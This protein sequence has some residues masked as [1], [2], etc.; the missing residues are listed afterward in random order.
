[1]I[2]EYE[3]RSTLGRFIMHI[4]NEALRGVGICS[5]S[6]V[7][8]NTFVYNKGEAQRVTIDEITYAMPAASILPLVSN[9]HF[10]FEHPDQIIAWQFNREFR[11]GLCRI[12]F[13]WNP[14][15]HVYYTRLLRKR[16]DVSVREN[17]F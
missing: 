12:S 11:S 16:S 9:Q 5:A 14:A 15:S 13:L 6:P 1:M 10:S 2:R 4:N 7:P 8:I 17:L 3:E